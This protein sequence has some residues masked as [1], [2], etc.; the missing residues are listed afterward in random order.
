MGE[1]AMKGLDGGRQGP[2]LPRSSYKTELEVAPT[3]LGKKCCQSAM[4]ALV[5][6]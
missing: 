5:I 3:S 2:H 4:E 1:C 6:C